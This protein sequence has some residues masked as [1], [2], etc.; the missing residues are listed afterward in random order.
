ME[1]E[2]I[3]IACLRGSQ[4]VGH[5]VE[6]ESFVEALIG[7]FLRRF[8]SYRYSLERTWQSN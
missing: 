2:V 6:K 1:Y 3:G 8:R 7:R 5:L 4:K